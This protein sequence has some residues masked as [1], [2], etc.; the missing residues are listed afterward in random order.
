[1]ES[2]RR[3]SVI[4]E[5]RTGRALRVTEAD[6]IN[7]EMYEEINDLP[8]EYRR[9]NAH[10]QIQSTNFDR[11]LLAYLATQ[12]GTRQAV[13]DSWQNQHLHHNTHD[14]T[15]GMLQE[16]PQHIASSY[17]AT[18]SATNH[19]QMPYPPAPQSMDPRQHVRSASVATP[20]AHQQLQ[21]PFT[22]PHNDGR[23]MY[24]PPNSTMQPPWINPSTITEGWSSNNAPRADSAVDLASSPQYIQQHAPGPISDSKSHHQQRQATGGDCTD[25]LSATL[26]LDSQ[27]LFMQDSQVSDTSGNRR[28]PSHDFTDRRYSYNPNGRPRPVLDSPAR[29]H[30]ATPLDSGPSSSCPSPLRLNTDQGSRPSTSYGGALFQGCNNVGGMG[31]NGPFPRNVLKESSEVLPPGKARLGIQG[32]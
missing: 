28:S 12:M 29:L 4:H 13:P 32:S 15:S 24:F 3:A 5:K 30:C 18:G 23:Q 20:Y 27:Q 14:E 11:R 6:V 26:P 1:M 7:E 19:R 8:S 17:L 25:P 22:S 9:L 31:S 21:S 2:A 16:R 10:L